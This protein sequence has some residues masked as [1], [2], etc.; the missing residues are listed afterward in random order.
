MSRLRYM[1]QRFWWYINTIPC[2]CGSR[3]WV[4]G[5][6]IV[7]DGIECEH[8]CLCANCKVQVNYF[9]YGSFELP[10]TRTE[11]VSRWFYHNATYPVEQWS[12][13][14]NFKRFKAGKSFKI[15]KSK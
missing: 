1:L 15:R 2:D 9:A 4:K 6:S 3:L 13:R 11:A 10:F 8:E 7:E 12:M 5:A 14:R